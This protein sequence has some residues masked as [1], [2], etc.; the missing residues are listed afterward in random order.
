MDK[1]ERCRRRKVKKAGHPILHWTV[2]DTRKR[3]YAVWE[4]KV[5]RN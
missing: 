2:F 5:E 1:V 3:V 4:E